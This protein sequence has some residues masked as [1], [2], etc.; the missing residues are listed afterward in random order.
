[1]TFLLVVIYVAFIGLGLPDTIL[2]A[3]WPLMQ[4][5]LNAPLSAAGILSIIVSIGT[6]VSSLITPTL[7]RMLGTGKLVALSIACTMVAAAG[8]GFA[9]SFGVMSLWAIPMGLGA[10]AIDVALN[11][12]AAI[13]LESKHTNWLHASWGVGACLGPAILSVSVFVGAGWRGAYEFNA[14]LLAAI[15][16]MMLVSLP[17]WKRVEKT[18]LHGDGDRGVWH[19]SGQDDKTNENRGE[20]PADKDVS[21]RAAL[22]VP[23]MKL[24]FLTF[25]FYS[26]LEISTGLWCGTYLVARGFSP[27]VGALAVSMMFA[28]VMIGRVASGFFAIKFTDMRLVH[29]G[30]AIVVVGC[31]TLILP[32]P[33]WFTPVCICFLGLGCA[34]VYPSLIH[35]TPARFGTELSGRAISIQMAGSYVGSVLMPPAF[36]FVASHFSVILWPVALAIFVSCL[37]ICVCLLDYVTRKKL[38]NAFAKER[39][40]DVLHQVSEMNAA[41]NRIRRRRRKDRRKARQIQLRK[42]RKNQ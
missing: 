5:D 1:M 28:C 20:N 19:S 36:G 13:H 8:Y 38:N 17:L 18:K 23:G 32:L 33:L 30:I 27:E 12:F 26:A 2:G 24:S 35:A 16:A 31:F 37:L 3:A 40:M 39:V 34:P 7:L 11:N 25:F 9:G 22:R 15:V 6:I 29:A 42:A 41:R 4:V 10:G 14:I 21:L